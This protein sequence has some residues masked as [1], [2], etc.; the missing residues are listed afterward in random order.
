M[1]LNQRHC[2]ISS[3][4]QAMAPATFAIIWLK[5]QQNSLLRIAY[6]SRKRAKNYLTSKRGIQSDEK[7]HSK[8]SSGDRQTGK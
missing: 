5:P 6:F 8:G 1:L 3:T 2:S 7:C 4:A